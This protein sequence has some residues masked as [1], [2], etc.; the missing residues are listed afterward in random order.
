MLALV[1]L[2]LGFF[3]P[4]CVNSHETQAVVI[5]A[6]QVANQSEGL[7]AEETPPSQSLPTQFVPT[8]D[9]PEQ[10]ETVEQS[11]A[12]LPQAIPD[13]DLLGT[14][15][16][17][18]I[19][20][21]V[22]Y[23]AKGFEGQAQVNYTNTEDVTLD[24]LYFRL[25]PNGQKSYGDGSL[26]VNSVAVNNQPVQPRLSLSDTVLEVPL[27]EP[28]AVGD[29][30]QIDLEFAGTV[31]VDFG[32]GDVS[33]GYGIYNYS[34]G[35][36]SLSGWY[37]I[38]AVYD[39]NGWNLDPVSMIGDSVYSDIAFYTVDVVADSDL[40]L[41]TT[42]VEIQQQES[43][44][45]MRWRYA[46]GP[47]R[48]FYLIMSPDYQIASRVVE[49]VKVN[50]Y[51][52]PEHPEGGQAAL[53]VTS[54]SLQIFN[55]YFGEYP[56]IEMDVV[57]APMQNALGVEYPGVFLIA[58]DLYDDPAQ[59]SFIVATA[60]EVAHQWWYSVVGNDVFDEPWLDESL[61][62]YSS[63]LYYQ[64]AI[65]QSAYRGFINYWQNRL[66]ELRQ[67]GLDD[68]VTR[69]LEYFEALDIPRVYG[70]VV[71]T[72]GALFLEALRKEIGDEAFFGALQSYYQKHKYQIAEADYLLA[73]FEAS[74]DRQLD[75]F[76][77]EWLYTAEE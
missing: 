4:G 29:P 51:Y 3:L 76:Y 37:P 12:L 22:D 18:T 38:L 60:H 52:L 1:V 16:H 42:G 67:D 58:S 49:G 54:R 61:A 35:V 46:S 27:S 57:E 55:Q 48:D 65:S 15:T 73:E 43:G 10:V 72:K 24:R 14:A 5:T 66:S 62:T 6:T 53:E 25:L 39:Q 59:D 7:S 77:Q 75:E 41:A 31:P 19:D 68:Q 17:Y 50:S 44:D 20:L 21:Q 11:A 8:R 34:Q 28:L 64:D 56:Y 74:A 33:T 71:Y 30:L 9:L 2:W 13:L 40:R 70:T 69:R 36:L 63:S 23:D 47:V 26:Q 45:D 32:E